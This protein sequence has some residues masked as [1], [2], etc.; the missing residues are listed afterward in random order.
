MTAALF[1]QQP[2][3]AWPGQAGKG[4]ASAAVLAAGPSSLDCKF[5]IIG[6]YRLLGLPR[7]SQSAGKGYIGGPVCS[8]FLH[9][10]MCGLVILIRSCP[11]VNV[12][13]I[14]PNADILQT[15]CRHPACKCSM[16]YSAQ[17]IS[18]SASTAG[19]NYLFTPQVHLYI[20]T[21]TAV[22]FFSVG[23]HVVRRHAL[24]CL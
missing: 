24:W 16:V 10:C 5:V 22:H 4:L 9:A 14:P 3:L 1:L 21:I 7:A 18:W 17:C 12:Q 6:P 23:D 19:Y 11:R 13:V 20:V 15:S 2:T 8:R